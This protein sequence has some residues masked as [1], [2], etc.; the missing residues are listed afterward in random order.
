MPPR[1]V[2]CPRCQVRFQTD[3]TG[4]I[5]CAACT[6][7]FTEGNSSPPSLSFYIVQNKQ[8]IG[9]VSLG[10]MQQMSQAGKLKP[11]DMVLPEGA[12]QWTPA[13]SVSGLFDAP[14]V[15][16]PPSLPVATLPQ[17]APVP[18]GETQDD[19]NRTGTYHAPSRAAETLS[20]S[21]ASSRPPSAAP[22]PAL[23]GYEIL[24]ELGRGGMGV[25]YKA[26]Q[27]ALKR[28]VAL[29]MILSGGHASSADLARFLA[30]AQASARLQHPNIVQVYEIGETDGL[31]YFS[32]EYVNGGTLAKRLSGTPLP[33]RD[34][35][36][37]CVTL[38]GAVHA[39]HQAGIIHRDLKPANI[40]LQNPKAES[41][42]PNEDKSQPHGAGTR[43][44]PV[45]D[46]GFRIADLTPK[47][48]DFGLAKTLDDDSGH[49]RTGAIMGT[50]YY[51][52]PEQA[53]GR[54]R[55][56][57][58]ATDVYALG[59]ILY[60][61]LT[62]RPPFRAATV[63]ETLEQV[64][65]QDP[66][67]PCSLQPGV[68]R[69]L[70][71]ITLKCLAKEPAQRYGSAREL[72]EDLQRFL[73][74]QPILARPASLPE[75]L[76]KWYKR[77]R[78]L[79]WSLVAVFL[80]MLMGIIVSIGQAARASRG[81]ARAI[82]NAKIAKDRLGEVYR[83][84]AQ[85][86]VQRGMH[87]QAIEVYK[88]ALE[89][90]PPDALALK[91][92]MARAYAA[93]YKPEK[94]REI[95]DDLLADPNI[96]D[97]EGSVL[98]LKA[99]TTMGVEVKDAMDMVRL[100]LRKGLPADED[101]FARSLLAET[102]PEAVKYCQQALKAN[103][104]HHPSH[105]ML[106]L[107]LL[108]LGRFDEAKQASAAANALFPDDPN[109]KILAA[110]LLSIDGRKQEAVKSLQGLKDQVTP[111][112][113]RVIEATLELLSFLQYLDQPAD[114]TEQ[115][116]LTAVWTKILP[117]LDAIWPVA[118]GNV[119]RDPEKGA[120]QLLQMPP[121][122]NK[123]LVEVMQALAGVVKS[124]VGG[125]DSKKLEGVLVKHPEGMLYYLYGSIL[126]VQKRYRDARLHLMQATRTPALGRIKRHAL[127]MAM[128]CDEALIVEC[129][130]SDLPLRNDARAH[131]AEF[132]KLV[133][134]PRPDE[135]DL[136]A[137]MALL[138]GEFHKAKELLFQMESYGVGRPL[139]I[140]TMRLSASRLLKEHSVVL[141]V[142]DRILK[143]DPKDTEAKAAR[144]DAIK[145]MQEMIREAEK[146]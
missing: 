62:G 94:T 137:R 86:F 130:N 46:F 10:D 54:T 7:V 51:M 125:A 85:T 118:T 110:M 123:S 25:V 42:N 82:A 138:T 143:L 67:S 40:L 19:R 56:I 65:S 93:I 114:A 134:T 21:P 6:T 70:E 132:L 139:D 92:D 69:D 37:L 12:R 103:P 122:L 111:R 112:Q 11:D 105:T 38:A 55:D 127:S 31:P 44:V 57:G 27:N 26:R 144:A 75:R 78:M 136:C 41:R 24:E 101:A 146:K 1:W 81:E 13:R 119:S 83:K 87:V 107:L 22:V 126:V 95:L 71:T 97:R 133:G 18:M 74:N 72:A 76:S 53:S 20:Y 108:L 68:P 120:G 80:V 113:F 14:T 4:T 47:V 60:E 106:G 141:E 104:Y 142:S 34:A 59:A 145:Q 39:A 124:L 128:L 15:V 52:S 63:V 102:S 5:R 49:T 121:V 30:E 16:A 90:D 33:P 28:I 84:Q 66:V 117:D 88:E 89:T 91:L 99:Y 2:S 35:A 23:P 64:R 32:L 116:R 17:A 96:G 115:A 140:L 131:L 77:N 8:K 109:M 3:A 45:S 79:T 100:A 9:P 36:Q 29:K 98:L 135:V 73:T 61:C 129:K 43:A 58:P 48:T 50:P